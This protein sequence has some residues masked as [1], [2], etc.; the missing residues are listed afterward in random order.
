[1]ARSRWGNPF[2][3]RSSTIPPGGWLAFARQPTLISYGFGHVGTRWMDWP[4]WVATLELFASPW[5]CSAASTRACLFCHRAKC[6]G[7]KRTKSLMSFIGRHQLVLSYESPP[8][9]ARCRHTNIPRH[10]RPQVIARNR[11]TGTRSPDT[12]VVRPAR[13]RGHPESRSPKKWGI[14]HQE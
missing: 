10:W 13:G 1:M 11:Q 9:R 4:V 14:P 8:P 12:S 7:R 6:A 5:E 3:P 2:M